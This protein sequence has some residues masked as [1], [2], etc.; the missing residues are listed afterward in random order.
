[1]NEKSINDLLALLTTMS[2]E[3]KSLKDWRNEQTQRQAEEAAKAEES[4]KEF[5]NWLD[6]RK[7]K[8]QHEQEQARLLRDMMC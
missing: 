8:E 1:M 2:D 6:E 3:I 4:Q 7:A 5:Q